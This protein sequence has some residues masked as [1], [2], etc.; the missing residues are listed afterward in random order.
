MHGSGASP[1]SFPNSRADRCVHKKHRPRENLWALQGVN[2]GE[3]GICVQKLIKPPLAI[4]LQFLVAINSVK[5]SEHFYSRY[6]KIWVGR[7]KN[8][9]A[10]CYNFYY[11]VF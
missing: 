7:Q 3:G 2:G 11:K 1:G 8:S 4:F 6:Y 5:F 10:L 9:Q